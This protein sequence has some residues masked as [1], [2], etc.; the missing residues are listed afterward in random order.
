[1]L[2]ELVMELGQKQ[3]D[4]YHLSKQFNYEL[5]TNYLQVSRPTMKKIVTALS[6]ERIQL[7]YRKKH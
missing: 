7:G 3:G 2:R 4:T 6:E 5:L 1:M